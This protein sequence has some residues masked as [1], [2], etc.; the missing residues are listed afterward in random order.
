MSDQI[1]IWRIG[2][3]A[4]QAGITVRTLHHYHRLGLLSPS[5]RTSGGHRC[6]TSKDVVQLQ[7]IIALRSCGLSLEEIG[8]VLSAGAVLAAV[9]VEEVSPSAGG[10]RH[11]PRSLHGGDVH[12]TSIKGEGTTFTV[13]WPNARRE[14]R[15]PA[16]PS[17]NDP[18]FDRVSR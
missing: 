9:D 18:E 1:R 16:C 8:S 6:Y 17:P 7:R 2:E 11:I 5:C 10:I 13:N 4:E 12:V 15:A 14:P 3:L